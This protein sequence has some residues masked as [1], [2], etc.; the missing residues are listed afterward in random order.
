MDE[1]LL[2]KA[3][4]II[5]RNNNCSP[6]LLQVYLKIPY[7]EACSIIEKLNQPEKQSSNDINSINNSFTFVDSFDGI[8][9]E[10][11]CA[12]LLKYNG[13]NNVSV[14]SGSGDY[15]VDILCEKDL[16]K[17]AI[18]CKCYSG[19]VGNHA[20][21]E[22]VS[23]KIFYKCNKAIVITNSYFTQAAEETARLTDAYLWDRGKLKELYLN[24][25]HN[26]Y[27]FKKY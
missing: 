16:N 13:Y 9:F 17:Y 5:K 10:L 1:S 27:N 12:D 11:F 25:L 22:V 19:N 15:G 4:D 6:S 26:G 23:G 3:T 20:V 21:Q 14:T 7:E 8:A 18:Q 24:A 2:K